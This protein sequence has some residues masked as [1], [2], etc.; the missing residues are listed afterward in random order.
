MLP[1]KTQIF[2]YLILKKIL[3]NNMIVKGEQFGG[4]DQWEGK[5]KGEGHG[6]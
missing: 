5:E 3:L 1:K 6:S 4:E 2:L